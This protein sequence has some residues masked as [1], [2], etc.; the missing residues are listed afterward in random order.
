[1]E[2]VWWE[3]NYQEK[4]MNPVCHMPEA[5]K[6]FVICLAL[7]IIFVVAVVA[8]ILW[9]KIFSKTGYGWGFGLLMFVPI[10]NLIM[11]CLLAFGD[12]PVLKELR[13]LRQQSNK[14]SV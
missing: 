6:I 13:M 4:D 11:L 10:A 14:P 5:A 2:V 3:N 9:C 1:V 7:V 12:W 8:I